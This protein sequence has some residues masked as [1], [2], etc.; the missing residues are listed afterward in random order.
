MMSQDGYIKAFEPE[1]IKNQKRGG[2]G[3]IGFDVKEE[4]KIQ[5][6]LLQYS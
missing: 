2:K 1:I 6:V 3:M 4:D 5:H